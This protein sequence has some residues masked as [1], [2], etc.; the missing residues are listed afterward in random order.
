MRDALLERDFEVSALEPARDE[1]SRGRGGVV[2][3]EA[4]AG[5]GKTT[6]LKHA[7]ELAL[8]A[9]FAGRPGPMRY[10]VTS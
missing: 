1:L 3:V 9:G 4:A 8:R 6:L 2:V 7:S 10:P 5:L